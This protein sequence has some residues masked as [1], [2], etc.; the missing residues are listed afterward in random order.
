MRGAASAARMTHVPDKGAANATSDLAGGQ[1]DVMLSNYSTLVPV[2]QSKKVRL[3]ATTARAP[4]PSFPGFPPAAA[5]L[6]DYAVEIWVVVFAPSCTPHPYFDILN[7][8][9]NDISSSSETTSFLFFFF[10]F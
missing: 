5:T 8:S 2:V 1:I 10:S 3:L 7:V 6:P 9:L 4:L